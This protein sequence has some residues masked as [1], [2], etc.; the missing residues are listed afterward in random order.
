MEATPTNNPPTP[1][2]FFLELLTTSVNEARE[3]GLTVNSPHESYALLLEQLEI[4]WREVRHRREPE[5]LLDLL[6][7]LATQCVTCADDLFVRQVIA[8]N[9]NQEEA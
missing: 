2:T 5:I 8:D 6:V 1:E 9:D 4:Y 7:N 3:A